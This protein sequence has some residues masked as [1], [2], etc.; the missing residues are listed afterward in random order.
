MGMQAAKIIPGTHTQ[1][2]DPWKGRYPFVGAVQHADGTTDMCGFNGAQLR[3]GT[4]AFGMSVVHLGHL[5]ASIE[6]MDWIKGQMVGLAGD[7][8]S[9]A[10]DATVKY[11]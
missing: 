11:L 7:G 8:G 2:K 5:N 4:M 10:V 9:F 6:D 1:T 3:G